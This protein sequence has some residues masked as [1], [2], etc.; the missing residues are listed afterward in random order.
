MNEKL[1]ELFELCLKAKEYGADCFIDYSPH[2]DLLTIRIFDNGWCA[3]H[4][5]N[6]RFEI[7]TQKQEYQ[8]Y[9]EWEDE[10]E[11]EI[12]KCMAYINKQIERK[13]NGLF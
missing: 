8:E 6:E 13:K 7:H 5:C 9:R 1:K 10:T 4:G 3:K 12:K 2:V 11:K